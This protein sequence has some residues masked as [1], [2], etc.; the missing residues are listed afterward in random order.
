[1]ARDHTIKGEEYISCYLCDFTLRK[2]DSISKQGLRFCKY[3]ADDGTFLHHRRRG[4]ASVEECI[5][6]F[7]ELTFNGLFGAVPSYTTSEYGTMTKMY[8]ADFSTM[9]S[10]EYGSL[11]LWPQRILDTE[12]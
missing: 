1:M 11:T 3:C 8:G 12:H 9:V 7:G 5:D 10:G 4:W 6:E 2:S